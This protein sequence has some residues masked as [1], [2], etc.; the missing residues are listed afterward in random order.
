MKILEQ[1]SSLMSIYIKPSKALGYSNI[2]LD[3]LNQKDGI[4]YFYPAPSIRD[5][6]E[7]LGGQHFDRDAI[8][9]ILI[10][11]NKGFGSSQKAFDN[12][13]LLRDNNTL[14]V[15]T[16]QQ[17]GLFG[18]SLLIIIKALSIVKPAMSE[19]DLSA[20]VTAKASALRRFP[21]HTGQDL[22]LIYFSI[23]ALV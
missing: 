15:V 4:D 7:Q 17:A 21:L 13:E 12:I 2:Y 6:A 8:A 23:S 1:E 3:F 18:G 22:I 20:T 16:G 19:I 11:Q 14:C 9:D 10:N 5:V